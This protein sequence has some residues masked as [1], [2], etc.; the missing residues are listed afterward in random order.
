VILELLKAPSRAVVLIGGAED[1]EIVDFIQQKVGR[2]CHSAV[3]ASLIQT[4]SLLARARLYLGNDTGPMHIA[5][6]LGVP[7][8][9]IFSDRDHQNCWTPFG[10]GHA[11]L[12][13]PVVCG[14]CMRETCH[15][16]PPPCL[17]AIESEE[18]IARTIAILE[19]SR[20]SSRKEES[21][22]EVAYST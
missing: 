8:V 20:A 16:S 18:V 14:G 7:C 4:A 19:G 2:N 22:G 6:L 15:T 5:G 13:R 10:P 12:R 1:H 11:I 17:Q 9:A 21:E 3:G